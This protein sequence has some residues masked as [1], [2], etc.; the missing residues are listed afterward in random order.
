VSAV[1][2]R[3][4][5]AER[6]RG[7]APARRRVT[8]AARALLAVAA[9]LGCL[10]TVE[11]TGASTP[12]GVTGLSRLQGIDACTA[13]S[14]DVM[15]A[16]W[17][18]TPYG[19]LG[20][21]LGGV[22]RACDQPNLTASWVSQAVD[23]GW[24]FLPIWVGPEAPCMSRPIAKFSNDPATAA[25]Q[26]RQ[27]ASG[28]VAAAQA[29]G[30]AK[31]SVIYY[32]MEAYET[33]CSPAVQAFVG[34]WTSALHA[35]G[36]KAGMYGSCVNVGD[37]AAA[38]P[39]PYALWFAHWDNIP[40]PH[41]PTCPATQPWAT[42]RIIKQWQGGHTETWPSVTVNVDSD[43]ADGIVAPIAHGTLPFCSNTPDKT[44]QLDRRVDAFAR[45]SSNQLI[46][47]W[48]HYGAWSSWE[49][50][51]GTLTSAP[52][53]VSW[54]P[55]RIDVFARGGS[56]Q[57]IH[58]WYTS[59]RWSAWESLGGVL[60]S[61]PDVASWGSGRLDVFVRGSDN[62]LYRRW[63][64][65]GRWSSG[66][67]NLG[68]TLTSAPGAVSWEPGRLDV[69]ARGSSNQLI[70]RW[71]AAGS[72]SAWESLGGVLSSAPDVASWGSGRLD[73]FVR[74]GNNRAYHR[75]FSNN[76]WSSGWENLGGT[77]TS[78]PG[79]VSWESGRLDVFARGGS[80]QLIH[81]LYSNGGWS[82]A[83]ESLGGAL[84]DEP[85]ASAW[86]T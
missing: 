38:A 60:I 75:L 12:G 81:R 8:R 56:K 73:V 76:R 44:P 30:F 53:A 40:G 69:F 20:I 34:G 84:A 83:W 32:D 80:N 25:V 2:R 61:A 58:R 86:A 79:A 54:G 36:W 78:A 45:N 70:H 3:P 46:H 62:R 28:A 67:Q 47:R 82:T 14:L 13:P 35:A 39:Q 18:E 27:E 31:G 85:D 17:N 33:T 68:G 21:Y 24:S 5:R 50:L 55:G 51:G 26:G 42:D 49:N 57:L 29:V 19:D 22:N 66:W 72:W 71:S 48:Y 23:T 64:G 16:L 7:P 6:A 63:Y 41:D 77:L 4:A 65:G 59:G 9:L 52:T 1:T 37:F 74:G 10:L 43:C 11:P 15:R